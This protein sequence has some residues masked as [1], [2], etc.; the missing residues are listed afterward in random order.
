MKHLVYLVAVMSIVLPSVSVSAAAPMPVSAAGACSTALTLS[1]RPGLPAS[2]KHEPLSIA[3]DIPRASVTV[4]V[5]VYPGS[6]PLAPFVASPIPEYP[7]DPYLQ[8]A[9]AEYQTSTSVDTV[10]AWYRTAFVGCGWRSDGWMTT[11]ASA[12]TSGITFVSAGNHNLAMEM[13]FGDTPSGGAY[14][15]YGAEEITYPVRPAASHLHGPFSK[16]RIALRRA[17][18]R[19]GQLVWN[20]VHSTVRARPAI[21]QFVRSIN[22]IT[23]YHTVLGI[24]NGGLSL[25]GPAWLSF[26]RSNGSV[27]RGYENGPGICGGLAV[28]GIRWL[29]DTGPI[30]NLIKSSP[31]FQ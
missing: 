14:I 6:R 25:F 19:K 23:E 7:A 13:T 17:V 4:S 8:T 27:V 1:L 24:C 12:L 18:M 5:P 29:V 21:A 30:W 3:W 22:A 10:K 11:N 20:V 2:A 9:A 28:N 16:V 15:A 26:V 31:S